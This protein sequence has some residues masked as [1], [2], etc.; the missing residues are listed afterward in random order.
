MGDRAGRGWIGEWRIALMRVAGAYK[1]GR[2][3][4]TAPTLRA[5]GPLREPPSEVI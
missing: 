5:T 1:E 4:T 2:H 3:P